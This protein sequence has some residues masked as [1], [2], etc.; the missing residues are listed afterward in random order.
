MVDGKTIYASGKVTYTYHNVF[1]E[2]PT[3]SCADRELKEDPNIKVQITQP[4]GDIGKSFSL[5]FNAQ[6]PK[7]LRKMSV[8]IDGVYIASFSYQGQTKTLNKNETVQ[9]G[10]GVTE[11]KHTL[12]IVV[13]DYA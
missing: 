2:T 6:G 8:M 7:N 11:G 5:A 3:Q 1:V 10:T 12:Q 13:F 9:I 4:N